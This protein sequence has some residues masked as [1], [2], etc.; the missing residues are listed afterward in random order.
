MRRMVLFIV[1]FLTMVAFGSMAM[2]KQRPASNAV[3]S[4]Q[5]SKLE[6]SS[7]GKDTLAYASLMT[8]GF[9]V[10]NWYTTGPEIKGGFMTFDMF[11]APIKNQAGEFLGSITDIFVGMTGH[12]VFAITNIGSHY[13]YGESGGLTAVP[14]TALKISETKPSKIHIVLNGPE[15]ELRNAPIFDPTKIDNPRY[16]AQIYQYYGIQPYWTASHRW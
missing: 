7:V 2:A 5:D 12:D 4:S 8:V 9:V 11:G 14:I 3:V 1:T 6:K 15:M 16:E 13:G 10:S